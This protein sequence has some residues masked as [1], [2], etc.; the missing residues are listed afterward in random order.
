MDSVNQKAVTPSKSRLARTFAKV[1]HIRAVTGIAPVDGIQKTKSHEKIK[2]EHVNGI[3]TESF[4]GDDEKLRAKAATDAFLAKLFA[5]ISSVKASYAQLQFAQS[6]Y[7]ADGIQSAD[8]F[9]VTE[10]KNLSEL[11]QCYLKK[12]LDECSPETTQ[13]LAE[14]QEQ[15]SLLKT[16]EVMG[17]KMD[18]QVKLKNSEIIFLKEKLGEANRENKLLEKRINSSGLFSV[19]SNFQLSGLSPSHFITVLRQTIKSIRS[20]VRLM[21]SEM[22]SVGWDLDVPGI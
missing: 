11:K 16:Y 12:Q 8:Q 22:E 3:R 15:K 13:L 9:V 19:P 20:F 1:L 21:I 7:D 10:L 5:S 6:P 14:I 2:H 17:K 18:S 4:D